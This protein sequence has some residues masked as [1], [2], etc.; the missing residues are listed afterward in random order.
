MVQPFDQEPGIIQV[1]S[2]YIGGNTEAP[3]YEQVSHGKTGHAEAVQI[4]VR[5][6]LPICCGSSSHH[7]LIHQP[8]KTA[9]SGTDLA[10]TDLNAAQG[11]Q[12]T[13]S[14]I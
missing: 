13:T 11:S 9:A 1:V 8:P 7:L 4:P 5:C 6:L 14:I 2:G 12:N 3:T 10:A